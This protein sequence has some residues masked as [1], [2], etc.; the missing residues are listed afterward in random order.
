V[1]DRVHHALELGIVELAF[2]R[3]PHAASPLVVVPRVVEETTIVER[4]HV[5]VAF[6]QTGQPVVTGATRR[7]HKADGRNHGANT[8]S[9]DE[10]IA[11][12]EKNAGADAA[13]AAKQIVD[14][15]ADIVREHDKL[16]E[17]DFAGTMCG[18]YWLNPGGGTARVFSISHEGKL[19][20]I[21]GYLRKAGAVE[22][23]AKLEELSTSFGE[24]L[25][26]S[27]R[28]P[29]ASHNMNV[30]LQTL[31]KTVAEIVPLLERDDNGMRSA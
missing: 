22:A 7:E 1:N 4:I 16:F 5:E 30:L 13:K 12:I 9:M 8:I 31:R 24:K 25:A 26:L 14:S 23:A 19:S 28:T 11:R 17:I 2:F 27:A 18:V 15:F 21:H 29:V 10:L 6:N 20:F 3:H